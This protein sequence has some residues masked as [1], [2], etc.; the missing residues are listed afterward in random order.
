M[1]AIARAI[2]AALILQHSNASVTSPLD[3]CSTVFQQLGVSLAYDLVKPRGVHRGLL[4]L[5]EGFSRLDALMLAY[6]ADN[7][8]QGEKL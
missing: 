1:N 7:L 3:R 4:Q 8:R 6:V 2:G 5:L